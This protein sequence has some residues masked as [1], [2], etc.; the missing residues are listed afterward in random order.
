MVRVLFSGQWTHVPDMRSVAEQGHQIVAISGF[1]F[2]CLFVFG[3]FEGAGGGG[4][5][6]TRTPIRLFNSGV[7]THTHIESVGGQFNTRCSP[8]PLRHSLCY[9]S[10]KSL[11]NHGSVKTATLLNGIIFPPVCV[12]FF[13]ALTSAWSAVQLHRLVA[14]MRGLNLLH[15]L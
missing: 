7:D 8:L 4:Q 14:S 12:C 11:V 6:A 15:P 9:L 2:C 5:G 1:F 10:K 13:C 3:F